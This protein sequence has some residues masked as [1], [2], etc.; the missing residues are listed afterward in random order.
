MA[1]K[2]S[3]RRP[4]GDGPSFPVDEVDRLLVHGEPAPVTDFTKGQS[5]GI[6]YPSCREL[7][8]RYGVAHSLVARYAKQ[9]NCLARRQQAE[10]RVRDL[11]D[12]K[13]VDL[14]A[15]ALAFSRD[16][17]VRSI[18]RYLVGFEEAVAEGRTRFDSPSDFN[19]MCRL[20]AF[21]MGEAE[22]RH[23]VCSD[24]PTLEE[25]QQRHKERI[26]AFGG[27]EAFAYIPPDS[28]GRGK[29]TRPSASRLTSS[30]WMISKKG[31][32]SSAL[33]TTCSSPSPASA[34]NDSSR[35]VSP[36]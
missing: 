21:L 16:D 29:S 18:D 25:L 15:D 22:S 23:E 8:E 9:H 17:Q 33:I 26:V 20:R 4:K 1:A 36:A 13:L 24:M 7:G 11:S 6:R 12:E 5:E 3:G 10:N 2:K 34:F 28:I 32:S 19:L 27:R 14:R 30:T 31:M 35:L